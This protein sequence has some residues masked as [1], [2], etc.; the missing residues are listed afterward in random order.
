M[1][2][3]D[4]SSYKGLKSPYFFLYFNLVENTLD[5]LVICYFK[6]RSLYKHLG[7]LQRLFHKTEKESPPASAGPSLL[8]TRYRR[9]LYPP[10][11][12]HSENIGRS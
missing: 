4:M 10:R 2:S 11:N 5:A 1:N 7:Y 9:V 6:E 3:V 12:R 8:F